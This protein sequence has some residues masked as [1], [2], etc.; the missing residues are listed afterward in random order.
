MYRERDPRTH[1][2]HPTSVCKFIRLYI[3]ELAIFRTI[4]KKNVQALPKLCVVTFKTGL[5]LEEWG[6]FFNLRTMWNAPGQFI[7]GL[8]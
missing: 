7:R 2:T 3:I 1:N 6:V 5:L 8:H 4:E